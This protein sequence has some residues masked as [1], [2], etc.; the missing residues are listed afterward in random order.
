ML[1]FVTRQLPHLMR[2]RLRAPQL[3]A[4]ETDDG[5][6][7]QPASRL[8]RGDSSGKSVSH[9]IS[10]ENRGDRETASVHQTAIR[11]EP[12]LHEGLQREKP[13]RRADQDQRAGQRQ[14]ATPPAVQPAD[15]QRS[16]PDVGEQRPET[17]R[18]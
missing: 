2:G 5:H 13:K 8:H 16:Q 6:D 7:S 17:D 11:A 12:F 15:K 18:Q 4:N 9:Q 3:S 10:P 14:C 1:Q